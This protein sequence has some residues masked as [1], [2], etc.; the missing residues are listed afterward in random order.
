MVSEN[1]KDNLSVFEQSV[2]EFSHQDVAG[3]ADLDKRSLIPNLAVR[4]AIVALC[5]ALFGYSMFMIGSNAFETEKNVELYEGIR[6]DKLESAVKPSTPLLEPSALYTLQETLGSYGEYTDYV[7]GISSL[8]D[9][10]RRSN[11]YRNLM[12]FSTNYPDTYAWIYVNH[13]KIDYPVMK[14]PYTDYYLYRNFMGIENA[15]GSI[16]ADSS[17]SDNYNDNINNVFYG[18]CMKNGSMFR[19]LKTFMEGANRNTLAQSMNIEVYTKEGLYVYKV[20][21][22]YRDDSNFYAQTSFSNDEDFLNFMDKA[23][24]MNTLSVYSPYDKNSRICT[25][26]TCANV[27]SNEDER[28]VLHGILTHFIPASQL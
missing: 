27:T 8:D 15:A 21:S 5:I 22:G 24:D 3:D 23:H 14:G 13:T 10:A 16:V 6:A 25:L 1:S 17:L 26:I 2:D 7:G 4:A 19:T 20:F 9:Q 12:S 11:Y 18:H 28:Y